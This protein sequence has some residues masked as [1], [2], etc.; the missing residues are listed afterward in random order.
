MRSA[1]AE[2]AVCFADSDCQSGYHCAL[3]YLVC[4]QA[5]C[6]KSQCFE[7]CDVSLGD[8]ACPRGFQCIDPYNDGS[9][10]V[11]IGECEIMEDYLR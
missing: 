11:C 4:V 3:D 6:A 5:L 10:P 1:I 2:S 9:P 8:E 7:G